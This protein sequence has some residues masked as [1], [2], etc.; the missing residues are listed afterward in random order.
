MQMK[1]K[2]GTFLSPDLITV[3]SPSHSPPMLPTRQMPHAVP[4]SRVDSFP[5]AV[6]A[7]HNRNASLPSL[8]DSGLES[9]SLG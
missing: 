8:G 7:S 6:L 1:I 5:A 3:Q 4:L 9:V 2:I